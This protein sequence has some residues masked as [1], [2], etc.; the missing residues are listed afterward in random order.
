ML[1]VRLTDP[2]INVVNNFELAGIYK[3]PVMTKCVNVILHFSDLK[4]LKCN[5]C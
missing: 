1:A 2:L 5:F 4:E 3:E